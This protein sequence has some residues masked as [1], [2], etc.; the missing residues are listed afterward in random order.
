MHASIAGR[1]GRNQVINHQQNL[2]QEV[3][4]HMRKQVED[5]RRERKWEKSEHIHRVTLRWVYTGLPKTFNFYLCIYI[6]LVCLDLG[7]TST[8]YNLITQS[9]A[10]SRR[11]PQ[12]L[13]FMLINYQIVLTK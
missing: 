8:C 11:D 4:E 10:C 5:G 2:D 13:T 1:K 9:S 7:A 6:S 12:L 3:N